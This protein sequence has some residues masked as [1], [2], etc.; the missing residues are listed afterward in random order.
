MPATVEAPTTAPTAV[1][2]AAD[3]TGQPSLELGEVTLDLRPRLL[4]VAHDAIC[5]FAHSRSSFTVSLVSST[6]LGRAE[7]PAADEERD[8]TEHEAHHGHEE[9]RSPRRHHEVERGDA[10]RREVDDHQHDEDATE[11]EG[12]DAERSLGDRLRHLDLREGN[13]LSEQLRDAVDDAAYES[14]RSNGARS[15]SRS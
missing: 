12:A 15:A 7:R 8:A 2:R 14:P 9:P 10:G 3:A 11:H 4:D 1:L 13:L 6:P 5:C